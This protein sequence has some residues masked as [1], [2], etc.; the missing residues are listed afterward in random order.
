MPTAG[1]NDPPSSIKK[2]RNSGGPVNPSEVNS[3][4]PSVVPSPIMAERMN[5]NW[6]SI[7]LGRYNIVAIVVE[8][9][10]NTENSEARPNNE[11]KVT[12]VNPMVP[13]T[14]LSAITSP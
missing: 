10:G 4:I 6:I 11:K 13:I 9:V 12:V 14:I 5:R 2:L 3:T 7:I 8:N 1:T